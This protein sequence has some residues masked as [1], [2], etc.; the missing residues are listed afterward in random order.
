MV[1]L[2][3][4]G[5]Y[6]LQSSGALAN[7]FGK[8]QRKTV[9]PQWLSQHFGAG[10]VNS[11]L[12]ELFHRAINSVQGQQLMTDAS[13]TG[14]QF[15]TDVAKRSGAAGLG[16]S[17][18]ATGGADIF[19]GSA[20]GAAGSSLQTQMKSGLMQ[21]ML[22]VANQ[23]VQDQLGAYMQSMG[24]Q[25]WSPYQPSPTSDLGSFAM[26]LGTQGVAN[27]KPQ[28]PPTGNGANGS[29]SGPGN[30][31]AAQI[32]GG[33]AAGM[34]Q[35]SV[36]TTAGPTTARPAGAAAAAQPAGDAGAGSAATSMQD[37]Q[38]QIMQNQ[39][40]RFGSKMSR[41]TG[42]PTGMVQAAS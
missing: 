25:T 37:V 1:P 21:S 23:M 27:Y 38:G 28:T 16:P 19:A 6:A 30:D 15:E 41:W 20:A 22:P 39:P 13:R 12:Q 35:G 42:R 34:G 14:Q 5:L 11:Q 2:A 40:S 29:I 18:G 36:G 26:N 31:P 3:L 24:Y 8:K 10:A 7:I 32:A 17:G 4:M 33:I 9:D